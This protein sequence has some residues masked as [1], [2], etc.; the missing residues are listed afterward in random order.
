MK[1]AIIGAP[2]AG[3]SELGWTLQ[4]ALDGGGD[5]D[6]WICLDEYAEEACDE[7]DYAPG[8]AGG[9]IAN[10]AVALS[11]IGMERTSSFEN[12]ITC[13]TLLET[14]VY[15]A[16]DFEITSKYQG[17]DEILN[18]TRRVEAVL[19]TLACLYADSFDYD[20]V[21]YLPARSEE[22]AEFDK[23]LQTAFAAFFLVETVPLLEDTM[24]E[25][26]EIALKIIKKEMT[27]DEYINRDA[28]ATT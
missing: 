13:G 18:N 28:P 19:K 17:E 9:Y 6:K 14:S 3:K 7:I 10:L 26:A 16:M 1:I 25:N 15:S 11:R 23:N 22:W 4:D 12:T 21:F 2:G 24:E 27:V 20:L 5:P 8:T